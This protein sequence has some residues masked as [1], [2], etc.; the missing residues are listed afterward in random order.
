MCPTP[1]TTCGKKSEVVSEL[2][3]GATLCVFIAYLPA[4]IPYIVPT[5]TPPSVSSFCSLVHS[6]TIHPSL[7]YFLHSM[8]PSLSST[9]IP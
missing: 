5:A 8:S 6:D 2:A 1:V 9:F 3:G 4:S 7:V